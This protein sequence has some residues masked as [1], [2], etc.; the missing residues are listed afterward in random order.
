M[1]NFNGEIVFKCDKG[2]ILRK[3]EALFRQTCNKRT[4][5]FNFI[6]MVKNLIAVCC[7]ITNYGLNDPKD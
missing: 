6:W 7:V 3:I 4:V 2:I 1:E 5:T